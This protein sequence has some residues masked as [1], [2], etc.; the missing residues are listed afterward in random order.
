MAEIR[1]QKTTKGFVVDH[2][3]GINDPDPSTRTFT[4]PVDASKECTKIADDLN[5][6]NPPQ[7]IK[8][9]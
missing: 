3:P 1:F 5:K 6:L 9:D 4:H 8:H 7:P 2:V